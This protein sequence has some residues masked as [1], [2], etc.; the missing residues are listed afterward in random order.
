MSTSAFVLF[1]KNGV[2]VAC[3]RRE[4][5]GYA[6]GPHGMV[7]GFTKFFE[8][9]EATATVPT[10]EQM[11]ARIEWLAAEYVAWCHRKPG[12][13]CTIEA[14]CERTANNYYTIGNPPDYAKGRPIISIY[15]PGNKWL[16]KLFEPQIDSRG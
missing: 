15:G 16:S 11:Y 14:N 12:M 7:F 13:R 2:Q 1:T 9:L 3:V 5:D 6:D 10:A 8:H 4:T